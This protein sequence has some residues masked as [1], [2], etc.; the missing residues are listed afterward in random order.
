MA[1][2]QRRINQSDSQEALKSL[3]NTQLRLYELNWSDVSQSLAFAFK[4]DIAIYD[5]AYLFLC[6]K[7]DAQ[8]ITADNKLFEK[9]KE[10]F[11]VIHISD[12]LV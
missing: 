1:V 2:K 4:I 5:A 3:G 11:K 7:L 12:Y 9:A 10:H 6:H 8:L